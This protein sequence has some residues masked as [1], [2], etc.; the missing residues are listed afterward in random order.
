MDDDATQVL[1]ART[2]ATVAH[3]GQAD[4]N[5]VDYIGH[6][7]RV[8]GRL[9]D[10]TGQAV[11]WLHDVLEDTRVTATTLTTLGVRADIIVAVQL[12]TRSD[13]VAS[14]DYYAAIRSDPVARAVKLADIADNTDPSRT[15]LLHPT[16]R[17][18]LAMK[19]AKARAALS[20]ETDES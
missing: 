7:R 19:Y 11:A 18:R 6:P 5:G 1:L 4:K 10:A 14:E 20:A 9:P 15:A 16:T 17:E 13:D 2:I 3:L 12:L 8:A